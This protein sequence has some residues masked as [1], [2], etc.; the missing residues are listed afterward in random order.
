MTEHWSHLDLVCW[1]VI[2]IAALILEIVGLARPSEA[3]FTELV[4]RWVP[5]FLRAMIL[6]WLNWHF[7]IDPV[8]WMK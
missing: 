6:G 7:L 1:A 5:M 8:N 3:T 4:R 2:L